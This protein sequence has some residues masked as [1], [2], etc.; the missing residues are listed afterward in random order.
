MRTPQEVERKTATVTASFENSLQHLLAELERIDLLIAAQVARARRLHTDDEQFRGLYISEEEIDAL[1]KQ[2]LGRPRWAR[3]P[4]ARN[5]PGPA[6][7]EIGR[8]NN[9]RAQE[10]IRCGIELRLHNLQ[11]IFGL[12]PFEIDVLLVCLAVEVDLRYEKLYAYLN[13][14][15]TK[16]RPSVELVV[17][18]LAPSAEAAFSARNY[19]TADAPLFRNHLL[20]LFEDPAQPHPPL[21][22]KYINVEARIVRYLLNSDVLD[23]RIRLF[24]SLSEPGGQFNALLVDDA[25]RQHLLGSSK[26]ARREGR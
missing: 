2:P 15:V 24:S 8:R 11:H 3:G 10:S 1:L 22:A 25:V 16:K 14:D 4:A 6:L 20:A 9:L 21:L 17:H 18:L 13:D 23:E 5:E 7:D 19:F 12:D 26:T